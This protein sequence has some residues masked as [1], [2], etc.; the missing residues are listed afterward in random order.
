MVLQASK[1]A[2]KQQTNKQT[3]KQA[4]ERKNEHYK[5]TNK[6]TNKQRTNEHYIHISVTYFCAYLFVRVHVFVREWLRAYAKH[7]RLVRVPQLGE[8]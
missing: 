4:N 3:N 1:Q 5:Q 2:S 8:E 6:Q 7:I